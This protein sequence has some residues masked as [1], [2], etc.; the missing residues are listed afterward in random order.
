MGRRPFASPPRSAEVLLR[1][2]V[3]RPG[4]QFI[5][6]DLR[7]EYDRLRKRW[8]FGPAVAWYWAQTLWLGVQLRRKERRPNTHPQRRTAGTMIRELRQ[9]IRYALRS[10]RHSP[11][12]T[13]LIVLTLALAIGLNT[14]V[15]SLIDKTLLAEPPVVDPDRVVFLLSVDSVG[16]RGRSGLSAPEFLDLGERL[17]SLPDLAAMET[18][19]FV[20]T[21][22]DHPIRVRGRATTPNLFESWGL[23]AAVGRV[24][25]SGDNGAGAEPVALL[26]YGFWVAEFGADPEVIGSEIKV[27]GSVATIVGVVSARAEYGNFAT[28]KLWL[29]LRPGADADRS[30]RSLQVTGRIAEGTSYE[31]AVAE[32]EAVARQLAEEY[33]ETNRGRTLF[34]QRFTEVQVSANGRAFLATLT[35][36]VGLVLLVA[37]SNVATIQ[38][39]RGQ[40]RSRE[41]AVRTVLGAGRVRIVRQL[42]VESAVT[43]MIAGVTGILLARGF[44]DL[45]VWVVRGQELIFEQLA[46]HPRVLLFTLAVTLLA[47]IL[48]GLAPALRASQADPMETLKEG[49]GTGSTTASLRGRRVLLASQICMAVM[50]MVVAGVMIRSV[51]V[52]YRTDHG[53]DTED[54]LTA[55]LDL[56]RATY[57]DLLRAQAFFVRAK[58]AIDSVPGIELAAWT[59]DRP[60]ADEPRSYRFSISGRSQ[61]ELAELPSARGYV[62]SPEFADVFG[63]PVLRGRFFK[64]A[65]HDQAGPVAVISAE[66]ASR[67][68]GDDDPIGS[69]INLEPDD[70]TASWHQVVGVVGNFG[71]PSPEGVYSPQV[72]VPLAQNPQRVLGLV[73]RTSGRPEAA[74]GELRRRL[75]QIDPE[76]PIGDIRTMNQVLYDVNATAYLLVTIF[77]IFAA[78]ALVMTACG[79]YGL[80]A[81]SVG[82]RTPEL[83][84]R[85]ALGSSDREILA[86]VMR[87]EAVAIA[88]GS[89][90]GLAGAL[91]LSRIVATFIV[92]AGYYD[93]VIFGGVIA[94]LS[95][96]ATAAALIPSIRVLRI[97]PAAALRQ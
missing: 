70:A 30:Q 83:G 17:Q 54:V 51:A 6:G 74:V 72:Y 15:F 94:T 60:F 53:L 35:I 32:A 89:L 79:I 24:F 31:Q 28:T 45:L 7:E 97:D 14:A 64:P 48:F 22:T 52:T 66:A 88:L 5:I 93:P 11:S 42:L 61:P 33:P 69:Q 8:G 96:V 65:D 57:P 47:P 12:L 46:I 44:L 62:V 36:T 75:L 25:H 92:G 23:D 21:G 20:V 50:L 3:L 13:I 84:L 68:W 37:C 1:R 2:L 80:T 4:N 55:R 40:L 41:I 34:V 73:A 76:Q 59:S 77:G 29:P 38:L 49:G 86:L 56:P 87:Q 16:S 19:D 63:I 82:Q 10:I 18:R 26:S 85:L 67:Y 78:F 95:A 27:D 39:A 43:S 71:M 90:A 91:G 81:F 9:D 58:E